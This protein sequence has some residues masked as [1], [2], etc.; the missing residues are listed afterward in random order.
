MR[1]WLALAILVTAACHR[2]KFERV[3]PFKA[4]VLRIYVAQETPAAGFK[5]VV[6][7]DPGITMYM[8]PSTELTEKHLRKIAVWRRG[9]STDRTLALTFTDDGAAA[10]A[11]VTAA[12][13]GKRVVFIVDGRVVTAPII[14]SRITE[15]EAIIEGSFTEEQ[16]ERLVKVLSGS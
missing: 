4:G 10:L 16:A 12:N 2:A 11:G 13:I 5:S 1:K 14:Q 6:L 15:G 8:D 3:A 7:D 9:D